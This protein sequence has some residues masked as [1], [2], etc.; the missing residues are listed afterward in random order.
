MSAKACSY[1]KST[2]ASV[3]LFTGLSVASLKEQKRTG[4]KKKATR[5]VDGGGI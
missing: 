4:E 5:D 1:D 2:G 3:A